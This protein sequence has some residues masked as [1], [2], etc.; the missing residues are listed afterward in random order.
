M[1]RY[2]VIGAAKSGL[3]SAA[4]LLDRADTEVI[5]NDSDVTKKEAV[6]GYFTDK[7]PQF[8][9]G[10]PDVAKIKPDLVVLSPG[11][12]PRIKPVQAALAA[13]IPVISEP[14]LAYENSS[15]RWFGITGTNGKT[16][17]TALAAHLLEG[18]G[19]PVFCGGN[20]GTPLISAVPNLPAE[21]VVVAELSSFQLEL[22]NRFH[23]NAAAFLNLTPDHLDRHGSMAAYGAAKAR[24]FENQGPQDVLIAN[25]DDERVRQMAEKAPGQVWYFSCQTVPPLGMWQEEGR[26]MVRL[27]EDEPA[28]ALIDRADI[29]LPGR[30]NTE[31]IMAA[32]LGALYFGASE[33]HICAQLR[34]FKSVAHRLEAVRTVDGVLYVNDSKG[35]NPD[36]TEKALNAYER[37]IVAIMGGRN[38]G[39]SFLPLVPLIDEKCRH[40]VLVGEATGDFI[41]AFQEKAFH[42]YSLADDF[43]QAVDQ[44]RLA[45]QEGDVVLLSPACA[46][47]DMFPSYEV[48]GDLFK[49]LVNDIDG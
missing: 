11:V 29:A 30:H 10:L 27:S 49:K 25:Y 18:F 6:E 3:A 41:E 9:W 5:L 1:K 31:N 28:H 32:V 14:E 21:A 46:S 15:A 35:T 44:A 20:I 2:L 45:A 7:K 42:R 24:I 22:I 47:W 39:N 34:T 23:A 17:T 12:P 37:P 26:L 43:E 40:V 33:A 36:A 38:K 19:A 48:R 8:V 13:G 16:T 4:Y